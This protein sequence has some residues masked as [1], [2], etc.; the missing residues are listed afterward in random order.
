MATKAIGRAIASP[1]RRSFSEAV[2]NCSPTRTLPPTSTSGASRSWATSLDLVGQVELGLLVEAAG[3]GDDHERGAAVAGAQGV[4]A[5]RPRV[6]DVDHAVDRGD[7]CEPGGQR[8]GDGGIV[9]V[10]A[11]GD[12]G[13]LAAGLGEVVELLGDAAGL[14]A[15]PGAEARVTAPRTPSCRRCRRR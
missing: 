5:G 7:A 15:G 9:D 1:R 4:G 12:D 6:G 14:G 13:D 11:V 3:E 8:C 2:P 10:D